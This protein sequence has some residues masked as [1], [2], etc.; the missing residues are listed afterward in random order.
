MG[1]RNPKPIGSRFTGVESFSPSH[2]DTATINLLQRLLIEK[3]TIK[4]AIDS[5]MKEV[6][7][8]PTYKSQL[9]YYPLNAGECAIKNL[10]DT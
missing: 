9:A 4:Q 7:P 2:T 5:I 8:D 10:E 6:G 1:L 3:Q